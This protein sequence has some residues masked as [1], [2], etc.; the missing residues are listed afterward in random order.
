MKKTLSILLAAT[1]I[2]FNG[3]AQTQTDKTPAPWLK[4]AT[5]VISYQLKHAVNTYKPG[6]NPRS[7]NPNGT[8]RLVNYKDW[9]TGFFPGSLWYGYE[10]TGDKDLAAEAKRFTL[11][12]DSARYIKNTHDVGFMLYCSYGNAYRLTGDKT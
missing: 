7:T 2:A 5:E 1:A 9:T 12:L 6:Q 4:K 11:A 8:V 3:Y 10:L